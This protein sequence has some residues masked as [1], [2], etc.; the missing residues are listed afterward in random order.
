MVEAARFDW[1][2]FSFRPS[3][4]SLDGVPQLETCRF[5]CTLA[6]RNRWNH[7]QN[8]RYDMMERLRK[9]V[10]VRGT[11]IF[12]DILQ[13]QDWEDK[14][15]PKKK[16]VERRSFASPPPQISCSK[17][18]NMT[19]AEEETDG[20]RAAPFQT[21]SGHTL[22]DV[23]VSIFASPLTLH[24]LIVE[25]GSPIKHTEIGLV[26]VSYFQVPRH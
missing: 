10:L 5:F 16:S 8:L 12:C 11:S 7:L 2:Y 19:H 3:L 23:T 25:P 17:S 22:H 20:V 4:P 24:I 6:T 18:F 21:Y 26:W 15:F 14:L 9:A 1:K 13:P